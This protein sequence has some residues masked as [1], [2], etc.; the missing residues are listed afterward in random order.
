MSTLEHCSVGDP[1]QIIVATATA[2]LLPMK[3]LI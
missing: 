3:G 1:Q 2:T